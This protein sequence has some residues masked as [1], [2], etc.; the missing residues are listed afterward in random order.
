MKTKQTLFILLCILVPGISAV[1]QQNVLKVAEAEVW[2]DTA[3][4]MVMGRITD[5]SA[6]PIFDYSSLEGEATKD[7]SCW[8]S[9]TKRDDVAFSYRQG[10]FEKGLLTLQQGY[11]IDVLARKIFNI[12]DVE[13]SP[14]AVRNFKPIDIIVV[15]GKDTFYDKVIGRVV[16]EKLEITYNQ[17]K[18]KED[19]Q[20][21]LKE[22]SSIEATFVELEITLNSEGYYQLT[23]S[24]TDS[25]IQG[26]ILLVLVDGKLY[27]PVDK[28]LLTC[29]ACSALEG[30][31][32]MPEGGYCTAA[33][34]KQPCTKTESISSDKRIFK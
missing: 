5:Q 27:E 11:I 19:W 24:N 33:S 6:E 4:Q 32:T 20:K 7:F 25:T 1:A 28:I 22:T 16:V 13:I 8:I 14:A 18:I 31:V 2:L 34:K 15:S 17:V 9:V 26:A 23:A 21:Y 10:E 29:T 3:T 12:E 30:P